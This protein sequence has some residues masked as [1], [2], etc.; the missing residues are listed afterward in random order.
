V[1]KGDEAAQV[2]GV[3]G[4]K[5]LKPPADRG[6]VRGYLIGSGWK[7]YQETGVVCG[8]ALPAV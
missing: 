6:V 8:I 1:V 2:R 4:C 3:G 5:K 7:D